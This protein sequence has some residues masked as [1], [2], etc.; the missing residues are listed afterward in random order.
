MRFQRAARVRANAPK[1]KQYIDA[2]R[3]TL[4]SGSR[5]AVD[6]RTAF[7]L[8]RFMR[9]YGVWVCADGRQVL[10]NR[11]YIPI[12][13]RYPNQPC[14][15]ANPGEWIEWIEQRWFFNDG[16]PQDQRTVSINAVLADWGVPPLPP[17]PSW[18]GG[19]RLS[20]HEQRKLSNPYV[21]VLA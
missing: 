5:L 15:P 3:Y 6:K 9:P 14:C 17:M 16:T 8:W 18:R 4:E 12:L 20:R 21:R 1:A 11:D 2:N 13:Q 10:F 19:L 7:E